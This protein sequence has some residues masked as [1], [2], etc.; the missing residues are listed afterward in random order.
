MYRAFGRGA[1]FFAVFSKILAK[2]F[3]SSSFFIVIYLSHLM[4]S[5]GAIFILSDSEYTPD[6]LSARGVTAGSRCFFVLQ[7]KFF[8]K[9]SGPESARRAR[10]ST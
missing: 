7:G 3:I 2:N 4:H 10:E 9:K 6:L 5:V 8:A 1:F